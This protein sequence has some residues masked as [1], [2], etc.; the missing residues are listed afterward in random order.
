MAENSAVDR[1]E[2]LF[3]RGVLFDYLRLV[4]ALFGNVDGNS[5]RSHNGAV[6]IVQRRFIGGEQLFAVSR[7][8]LLLG[9]A[10]LLGLHNDPLGFDAGG[11]VI[12]HIPY[13][14]VALSLYLVLGFVDRLAEAVV[15]LFVNAVLCLEPNQNRYIVD[16]R[17][18]VLPR[19]PGVQFVPVTFLPVY[20]TVIYLALRHR[21]RPYV[22]DERQIARKN[23]R[24]FIGE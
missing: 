11:V 24:V 12:F 16:S 5:D 4:C 3:E 20:E 18:K 13:V 15:Y 2:H 19:L 10:G 6:D 22:I 8:Y 1:G 7:F 14:R 21:Q 9:N 17:V 23:I